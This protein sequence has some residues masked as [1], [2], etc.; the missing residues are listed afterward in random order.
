MVYRWYIKYNIMMLRYLKS[1]FYSLDFVS[2][3]LT[4]KLQSGNKAHNT[5]NPNYLSFSLDT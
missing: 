4:T 1:S 5:K 3:T 2:M